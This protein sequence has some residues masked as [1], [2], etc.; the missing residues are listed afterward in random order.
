MSL[1][2]IIDNNIKSAMKSKDSVTLESLR[3]VKSAILLFKTQSGSSNDISSEDEINIL[4]KLVKQRKESADIYKNQNRLEL[5]EV[6]LNQASVIESYLPKQMSR[7]EVSEV[8]SQ[9]ITKLGA[10]TM[11]EMGKVMG[12]ASKELSGKSDGKTI[13]EIVRKKLS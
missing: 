8:I 11:K 1:L 5:S 6:E 4:Q 7:D 9:I 12:L 10:T 2:E 3:A 13:S